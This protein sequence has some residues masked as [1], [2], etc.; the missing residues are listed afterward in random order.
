MPLLKPKKYE[1]NKDFTQRCMGNAKMG[2]EYSNR[3]QRF[4]VCQ[5]IW[6]D[7]FNPNKQLQY[8]VVVKILLYIC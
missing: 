8:F 2:E 6:K 7:T 5:T 3:D 1:T 4:S